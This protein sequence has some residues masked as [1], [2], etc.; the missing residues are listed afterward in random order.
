M[1]LR[2]LDLVGFKSFVNRTVLEFHPGITAIVGPNGSGKSNVFD[3]IRWALG[4]ANARMLRGARM[5]DVIFAGT[6]T[7]KPHSTASVSLTLDNADGLLPM[8]F[9]EICVSRSVTRGGDGRYAINGADCRLRDVQMLFLGTGLGG[10]SY[11]LIGQGE[12]DSVL[13]ATPVERR[14]WLEE[15]AGLARHKRQRVEA[16]RRLSHAASHLERLD[17]LVSELEAQ[18][19]VLAAQAEAAALHRAY[20]EEM[21]GLELALYADEARRLL[22]GSRRIAA[23]LQSDREEASAAESRV[24]SLS[25]EVGALEKGLDAASEAWERLQQALLAGAEEL[26]ARSADVQSARA[27]HEALTGRSQ[28]LAAERERLAAELAAQEGESDSLSRQLLEVE[29]GLGLASEELVAAE[30]AAEAAGRH[31]SALAGRLGQAR[32]DS[33]EAFRALAQARSDMAALRARTEVLERSAA[34]ADERTEAVR[35]SAAGLE[36]EAKA[37]RSACELARAAVAASEN[38]LRSARSAADEARRELDR[39]TAEARSSEMEEHRTLAR[40]A[41]AEEATNQYLG[42]EEGT[43][44]VLLAERSHPGRF[45][46]LLGALA[47]LVRVPEEYRPAVSAALGRRLHCLIVESRASIEGIVDHA[48]E[49]KAGGLTLLA[50]GSCR[51]RHHPAA[52]PPADIDARAADVVSAAPGVLPAVRALLD[53][54]LI[55][56]D[57]EAAWRLFGNGYGGRIVT[58]EGTLLSPDGVLSIRPGSNGDLGLLSRRQ[59]VE[60]LRQAAAALH[61]RRRAEEGTREASASSVV[62]YEEA[63]RSAAEGREA[64]SR[65]LA[66][67]ERKTAALEAEAH[68]AGR[69]ASEAVEAAGQWAAELGRLSSDMERLA[70]DVAQLDE[71]SSRLASELLGVEEEARSAEASRDAAV[72]TATSRRVELIRVEGRIEALRAR[73]RERAAAA[74][75]VEARRLEVAGALDLLGVAI[76]QAGARVG[77]AEAAREARAAAQSS[78]R[79]E[80]DRLSEQRVRLRADLAEVRAALDGAAEGLR[81]AEAAVH[82]SELRAAQS[83]AELGAASQRLQEQYGITLEDAAARRLDFPRDLARARAAELRGALQELGPVNMRAIDEHAAVTARLDGLREQ[84][85]DLRQASE[86]LRAAIVHI[87]SA[88]RVRFGQTFREVNDEF[89]RLFGQLFGGGEGLLELVEDEAGGE[90]GMEVTAQ[91]PGKKRRPLVALSGGER[92]LVAL[93]LIFA[94]LRVHPSPFCIFDEVEAALDDANTRRFTTL[95]RDLAEK[96]Q[97]LIVTHNKGTMAAADVLYGVTMQEPGVSSLV[98]VRLVPSP[99]DVMASAEGTRGRARETVSL[100]AD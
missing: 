78:A 18:Q 60:E 93:A 67:L 45:P 65:A 23:Q 83:E 57:T 32:V 75:A 39:V 70:V 2:R 51:A 34:S 59:V 69:E 13:R 40:L 96:T 56:S 47:E 16:E 11:A 26:S 89:G 76:E 62:E 84:S 38:A 86:A 21:Q 31:A 100:P 64:A 20:V 73:L 88:L 81:S 48:K 98:S 49:E 10:R 92:V 42:F 61:A 28:H 12:V 54:V 99:D 66:D 95:L 29:P 68:R 33:S 72:S 77:E 50:L 85:G 9:S 82:R 27:Q 5:E 71:E 7:R 58:R 52:A 37:A 79:G 25:E 53:D 44:S 87:N 91:L 55:V 19:Q 15:A 8:E 17:D 22:L 46:G 1:Q 30:A 43:R 90:P 80:S 14:Q 4:E 74:G 63:A 6:A 35:A 24:S 41:S 97:V 94:M 3:G 36:A